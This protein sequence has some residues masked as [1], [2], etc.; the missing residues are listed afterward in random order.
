VTGPR[1]NAVYGGSIGTS[2]AG[3]S[4]LPGS[5]AGGAPTGYYF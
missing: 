1:F 3:L 2:G 4:Y 5:V